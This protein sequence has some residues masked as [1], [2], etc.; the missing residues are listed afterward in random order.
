[1]RTLIQHHSKTQKNAFQI[2]CIISTLQFNE[3]P[4]LLHRP[5]LCITSI[6]TF[7]KSFPQKAEMAV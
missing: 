4:L 7:Y 5:H 6:L 1:L 2:N 3:N